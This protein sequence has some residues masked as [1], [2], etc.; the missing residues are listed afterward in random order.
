MAA[1]E[2]RRDDLVDRLLLAEDH[3]AQFVDDPRDLRLAVGD[4]I[5]GEQGSRVCW[6]SVADSSCSK[7]FFTA[8]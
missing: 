7:Y 5:G 6:S 8:L 4:A 3:A 1:R 2:Q